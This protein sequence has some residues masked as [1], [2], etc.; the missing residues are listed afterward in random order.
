[1]FQL[2]RTIAKISILMLLVVITFKSI[3][4]YSVEAKAEK[5]KSKVISTEINSISLK[6]K[7]SKSKELFNRLSEVTLDDVKKAKSYEEVY[8]DGNAIGLSLLAEIPK[9]DIFMYGYSDEDYQWKGIIIR[10]GN[11]LNYFDWKYSYPIDNPLMKYYDYD[12]DGQKEL[13]V[14]LYLGGG[15]GVAINQLFI[16]ERSKSGKLTS[17]Q[18]TPKNYV[19]QINQRISYKINKN[20]LTL[21]DGKK[22]L[23]ETKLSWLPKNAHVKSIYFGDLVHFDLSRNLILNIEAGMKIDKWAS[24]QYDGLDGL[25]AVIKYKNGKFTISDI[26]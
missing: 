21:Y 16:L 1:M 6:S 26:K 20:K 13:A 2:K 22:K 5:E 7:N 15:T 17:Y 14:S 24:L 4:P 8:V 10:M 25:K 3:I 11:K 23:R 19:S 12:K 9:D 18:F